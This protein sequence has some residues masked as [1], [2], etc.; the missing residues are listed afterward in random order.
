MYVVEL[1]FECFD[2]TTVSAVD[3][4]VNGLMDA[5]RYNGQVLGR[6][7]P[8]VMGDGQFH[9]RAVCPE[10][11]SL[12]PK[13]HSP[14]VALKI[15]QLSEASLLSPKMKVLGR[16]INSEASAEDTPRSWQVLYTTYVHTC[17][18]LRCGETLLP[19]PLHRLPATFNGDHKAVVKWQ[20]EWQA[21]DEIQMA[22]SFNAEYAALAEIQD[23]DSRLFRKGWDIRG[24]IEYLTKVPTY[25]YQY[26]VGG[27]S[28]ESELERKCPK[29]GGDWRLDS[30]LHDVFHFKCDDCRI[31][32]NLSWDFQ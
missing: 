5:L 6:E 13:F 19:I 12:N 27:D 26:R 10:K 11:D 3:L 14:Q 28:A 29:C 4:A 18:P 21:C 20:T 16:D 2:D 25:Y 31:V 1:T 15:R 32:S 24:R 30:P 8:M 7:F 9:V 22:G 23:A 17:S